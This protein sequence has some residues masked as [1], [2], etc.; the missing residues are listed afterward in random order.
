MISQTPQP[1]SRLNDRLVIGSE[2]EVLLTS[3]NHSS[4]VSVE[5]ASRDNSSRHLSQPQLTD[6]SKPK[7]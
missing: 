4:S 3:L 7:L 2:K 6:L 5:S 1:Y